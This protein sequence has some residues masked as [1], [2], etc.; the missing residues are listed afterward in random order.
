MDLIQIDHLWNDLEKIFKKFKIFKITFKTK[1][2]YKPIKSFLHLKQTSVGKEEGQPKLSYFTGNSVKWYG[3]LEKVWQFP[4]GKDTPI[5]RPRTNKCICPQ[6][7][8]QE[9][10]I[11]KNQNLQT[12][13]T[14]NIHNV[15]ES[16]NNK[17][18]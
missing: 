4:T 7:P 11:F 9:R 13:Q 14:S 17:Q 6:T 16:Q 2:H 10:L 18:Q 8:I 1:I 3:H 12:I 5:L 15:D